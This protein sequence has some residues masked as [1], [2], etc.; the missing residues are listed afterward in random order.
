MLSNNSH[1]DALVMLPRRV[2]RNQSFSENLL[3]GLTSGM[4]KRF[5]AA[6]NSH[7]L[8]KLLPL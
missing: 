5:L 3:T 4:E 6:K 2:T 8:L 7:S 1:P